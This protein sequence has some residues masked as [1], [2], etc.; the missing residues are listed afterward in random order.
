[1]ATPPTP[2]PS[3]ED[4]LP[5][6]P[7]PFAGHIGKTWRESTPDWPPTARARPGAPNVVV[8]VL[9]D[10]GFGQ[11]STY[12]GP[13][14]MPAAERLAREGLRYNNFHTAALCSPTRA[15]LLSGRN[16]HEVGF[17][18][19]AEMAA[20]YPGAN[21]RL[22]RSAAFLPEVLRHHGY[23]TM[24]VGKWHLASASEISACGPFDRWPLGM[25][26]Q[27]FYGFLPAETDHWHPMLTCDNHRIAVPERAGYHLS[28]DLADQAIGML[29]S[30]QQVG[31]GKPFFL[32]M[33]FGAPHCPFHVAPEWI[34]RYRGQFD[35]GWDALREQTFARQKAMGIV[36]ADCDLPPR[37]PGVQA[38]DSLSADER[39]LFARMMETFA[40][41]VEHTDA[42]I[43]RVLDALDA[44]G[45]AD[46]T[47]VMLMSDNGASQEGGR[48]GSTNTERFRNGMPMSVDEMLA[49]YDRIGGHDTDVH[50]P[51]GWGM[52][53]NT[54]FR[55]WKRD[56]HRGGNTDPLLVRWPAALREGGAIRS[57]YLYVTDIYPTVLEAAG[58]AP[59][60]VVQG[61][62]QQPLSG[63]SFLQTIRDA[64]ARTG[65]TVQYYE[66]LGS[67]AIWS[68]GWTAVSWH[69]AGTDWEQEPWELYHLET[70]Y[71]QAH[72]LA[73]QHPDKL[74]DLVELWWSEARRNQV[75]P[76]DDRGREK[77]VDPKRPRVM[78][79]L[80]RYTYYPGTTPVPFGSVPR[81]IGRRHAI[82]AELDVDA[83]AG[84]GVLMCEG[85][86]TGGWSLFVQQGRGHYVHNA[87]KLHYA[88][89]STPQPLPAGRVS[90]RMEFEPLA[91]AQPDVLSLLRPRH[92]LDG[93]SAELAR[94]RARLLVNGVE[95]ARLDDVRTAPLMY[96]FVVEGFQIGRNWGTPVAYRHYDGA[97]EFAGHLLRVD[98]EFPEAEQ[99]CANGR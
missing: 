76:L 89:L 7:P 14:R 93:G 96:S 46:D 25:G 58:I 42:Q 67:R 4:I 19:I 50:Y 6:E 41:F 31:S 56:T 64:A 98:V 24:C 28:E 20:G 27:R 90:L 10:L 70:D 88:T 65:R 82:T 9:D 1:M 21:S 95:V 22:P 47:L 57:Q 75:L 8:V 34:E 32:Y 60:R 43:G 63:V 80:P 2:E 83:L 29:R 92:E 54:P 94:G 99:F 18:S 13:I 97:C 53:G 69:R 23:N 55:R 44:M 91:A 61:A 84:D 17:A 36:P 81:L 33:A 11:S 73:A 71:S 68:Q 3:R 15:A 62:A 12:G 79:V 86:M 39:R 74:R 26:F 38:W 66:M 37:N 72:D 49:D 52:A 77:G 51:A 5:P 78:Q 59:P 35:A 30:Q 40:G 85:G 45:V 16:H 48:W 87:L